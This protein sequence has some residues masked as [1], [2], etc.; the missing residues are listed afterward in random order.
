MSGTPEGLKGRRILVAEDDYHI[1]D[2]L[3]AALEVAGAEVVGPASGVAE[4][5]ALARSAAGLD[6]AVLD[7]NLRGEMIWPVVEALASRGVPVVLATGYDAG[8][9][10]PAHGHLPRREKPVQA[11]ELLKML[12]SRIG[13]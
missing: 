8:M 4:A 7:V 1:A 6:G 11:R 13:G 2:D 3:V 10:P 9:I 12:A 5:L